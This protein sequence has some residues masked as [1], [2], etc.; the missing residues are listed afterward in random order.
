MTDWTA[1]LAGRHARLCPG[2]GIARRKRRVA[3]GLRSRLSR[4][5]DAKA[6]LGRQCGR[7]VEVTL[8]DALRQ[9]PCFFFV[10]AVV[11]FAVFG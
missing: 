8:R 1:S 10:A 4:L 3:T 11:G 6:P 5:L 9:A 7:P 2:V